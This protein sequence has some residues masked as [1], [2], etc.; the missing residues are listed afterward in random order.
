MI[1]SLINEQIGGI[2]L[3][4]LLI[5]L[6]L[7]IL[8]ANKRE[9]RK[10]KTLKYILLAILY[11]PLGYGLY[12]SQRSLIKNETRKGGK[13]WITI[14]WILIINTVLSFSSSFF[15]FS[16][17]GSL[18]IVES[19]GTEGSEYDALLILPTLILITWFIIT[20]FGLI[21]GLILKNKS[22]ELPIIVNDLKEE[23]MKIESSEKKEI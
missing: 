12:R 10:V 5:G 2:L 7:S 11:P 22:I 4:Q 17:Y 8:I 19:A 9:K 21:I 16:K 20:F 13:K 14:K 1:D 3:I 23:D 18:N 15:G 6:I